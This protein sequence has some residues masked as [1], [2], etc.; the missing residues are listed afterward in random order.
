M[1]KKKKREVLHFLR[2]VEEGLL[3]LMVTADGGVTDEGLRIIKRIYRKLRVL[4]LRIELAMVERR[5]ERKRITPKQ[6]R[7]EKAKVKKRWL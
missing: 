4:I 5:K 2:Y 1:G 6:A 3:Q 7:E